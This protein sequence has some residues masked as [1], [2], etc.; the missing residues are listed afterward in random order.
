MNFIIK[1]LVSIHYHGNIFRFDE[2]WHHMFNWSSETSSKSTLRTCTP[3]TSY[4]ACKEAGNGKWINWKMKASSSFLFLICI[5]KLLDLN[6]CRISLYGRH[7]LPQSLCV[8]ARIVPQNYATNAS[9]TSLPIHHSLIIVPFDTILSE[10]LRAL[11][12]KL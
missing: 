10:L 4:V 2:R 6:I 1:K 7:D 11:A 9:P 5:R 8:N 12:G 3:G